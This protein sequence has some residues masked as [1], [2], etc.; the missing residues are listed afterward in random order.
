MFEKLAYTDVDAGVALWYEV[1]LAVEDEEDEDEEDD[2]D[3]DD[4][5]DEELDE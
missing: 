4:D 3:D 2:D 1:V 5:D